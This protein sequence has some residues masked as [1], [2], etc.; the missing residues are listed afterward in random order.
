MEVTI[1]YAFDSPVQE[2]ENVQ[3]KGL[4]DVVRL[5]KYGVN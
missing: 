4:S 5:K 3:T 1:L 2:M